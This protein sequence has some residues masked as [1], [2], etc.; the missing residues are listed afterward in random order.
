MVNLVTFLI[1]ND[2]RAVVEASSEAI[3]NNKNEK[4]T[5]KKEKKSTYLELQVERGNRLLKSVKTYHFARSISM[6]CRSS[7]FDPTFMSKI[8]GSVP[9]LLPVAG[10]LVIDL[11]TGESRPRTMD[12][13]FSRECP[14]TWNPS[15]RS[16]MVNPFF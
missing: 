8:D 12:D 2:V 6:Y 15:L 13:L 11:R 5:S 4:Q 10:K 16:S 14:V 7:L 3:N 9:H 1:N